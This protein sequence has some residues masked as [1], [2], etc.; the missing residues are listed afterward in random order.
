VAVFGSLVGQAGAFLPG[1][2][3]SLVVAAVL[4]MGAALAILF[5]RNKET[6]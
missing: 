3:E 5:G 4:L 1:A 6:A 2:R